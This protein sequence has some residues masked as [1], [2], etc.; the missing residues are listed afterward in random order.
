MPQI[1]TA[2]DAYAR[3]PLHYAAQEGH[4]DL[5]PIL[6]EFG[7][8]SSVDTE[9]VADSLGRSPLWWAARGGRAECCAWLV[10]Y[11][12]DPLQRDVA[13]TCAV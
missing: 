4:Q 3:A 7:A 2:V 8:S 9:D 13:G 12:G 6:V 11:N 5:L 1:A 10:A